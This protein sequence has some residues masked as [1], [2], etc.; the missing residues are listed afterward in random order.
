VTSVL[1]W[2]ESDT[3]RSWI[4]REFVGGTAA[5]AAQRTRQR[6]H[7]LRAYH[8]ARPIDTKS[9]YRKGIAPLDR[10][11]WGDLVDECFLSLAV[12]ARLAGAIAQARDTQFALADGRVHFCF[13]ER[14]LNERDGYTLIYGSLSLLAV[15]I[16]IDKQFGTDFK[17]T[18]RARGEPMV[19][20]CDIPVEMVEDD[21]LVR[22]IAGLHDA[23]VQANQHGA[24]P[25]PFGFH[26]SI[27]DALPAHAII[28][29]HGPERVMDIVYGHHIG[30][31]RM[32][33]EPQA[34]AMAH[35]R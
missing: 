23:H 10:A 30:T 20:V 21:E 11:S 17:A 28:G 13:D 8:A 35:G 32:P 27:P 16:R 1:D 2:R 24:L 18:L 14:L 12:D 26:F 5:H 3:W 34:A 9:Y 22:L 6:F 7:A 25:S 29:H 4:A 19:F 15:A 33:A 31:E